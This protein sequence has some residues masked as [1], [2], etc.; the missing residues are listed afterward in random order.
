MKDSTRTSKIEIDRTNIDM[1][2]YE[3]EWLK[4]NTKGCRTASNIREEE[5]TNETKKKLQAY[6]QKLKKEKTKL[7]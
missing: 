5:S 2:E 1:N 3:N 6:L 4:T 7:K